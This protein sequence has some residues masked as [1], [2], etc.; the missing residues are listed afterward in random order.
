MGVAASCGAAWLDVAKFPDIAVLATGD[1]LAAVETIPQA[2]Q[3][4]QSNAVS[5]AAALQRAGCPPRHVGVL[6]DDVSKARSVL[7][8]L[9]A[10]NSWIVLTGAV[11]KGRRDF[12]PALFEELGCCEIFHRI[13]Q[14]P[15][16]PAGCWKGMQGQAIIALPGNPVSALIG[17]HVLVLPALMAAGFLTEPAP[18]LVTCDAGEMAIPGSTRHLPMKLAP[19]G[20]GIPAPP[21]NSGDFI[22]LLASD[23]FVTLPPR[24]ELAGRSAFPF[25]PWI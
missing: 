19:D 5:L 11:S 3:I 18:R 21:G 10:Q 22:G 9:L 12:L 20:R 23:G 6:G 4:R 25:T 15:A 16:H 1:E 2:H 8:M 17:L 14:R 13:A 24:E 7:K